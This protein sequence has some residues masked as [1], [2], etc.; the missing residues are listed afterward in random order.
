[1]VSTGTCRYQPECQSNYKKSL[2]ESSDLLLYPQSPSISVTVPASQILTLLFTLPACSQNVYSEAPG[3]SF[4]PKGPAGVLFSSLPPQASLLQGHYFW[5]CP[6]ADGLSFF[7]PG[8]LG[9]PSQGGGAGWEYSGSQQKHD[10]ELTVAQI[11][12]SLLPNSDLN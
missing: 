9:A 8:F 10:W 2:Y 4:L 3:S 1:M 11:M 12:N 7:P 6:W 5:A